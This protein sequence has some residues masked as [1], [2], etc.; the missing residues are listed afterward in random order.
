YWFVMNPTAI[1]RSTD[2]VELQVRRAAQQVNQLDVERYDPTRI[3]TTSYAVVLLIAL[4]VGLNFVPLSQN[5]NW[6]YLQAAPAFSLSPEEQRLISKTK[7]LL[8][9]A[10]K[11]D[12]PEL[13]KKLEEIVQNL[14]EGNIDTAEALPQRQAVRS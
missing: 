1:K 14:Q 5:H 10:E 9:Q 3:P 7:Q 11:L 4:F 6:A 8:K 12:Q 13:V 2:W